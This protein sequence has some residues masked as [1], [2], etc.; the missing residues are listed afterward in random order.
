MY[1]IPRDRVVI[2]LRQ[3]TRVERDRSAFWTSDRTGVKAIIRVSWAFT[4]PASI[5]KIAPTP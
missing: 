4:D 1:G 3:D 5:T 2:A